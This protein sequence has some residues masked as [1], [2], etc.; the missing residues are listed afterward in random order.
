MTSNI[1]MQI[2][3]HIK[4]DLIKMKDI[5]LHRTHIYMYLHIGTFNINTKIS[6]NLILH[7]LK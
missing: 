4:K 1:N 3:N 5:L 6:N 7:L 2:V